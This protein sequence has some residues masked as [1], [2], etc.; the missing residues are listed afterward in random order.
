MKKQFVHDW[1]N[2]KEDQEIFARRITEV[3]EELKN[4]RL[5]SLKKT[6]LI[7]QPSFEEHSVEDVSGRI[8]GD[9]KLHFND[10]TEMKDI[11]TNVNNPLETKL[12]D[13]KNKEKGKEKENAKDKIFDV[14]GK[15]GK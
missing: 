11:E 14:K 12:L 1:P 15:S 4:K 3:S 7:R 10:M 6:S 9:F 8:K 13:T 5:E 2:V